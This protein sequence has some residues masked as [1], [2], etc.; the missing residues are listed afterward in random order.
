MSH[1]LKQENI[2][3]IQEI[4]EDFIK[5]DINKKNIEYALKNLVPN[6]ITYEIKENGFSQVAFYQDSKSIIVNID[7]TKKILEENVNTFKK[8]NTN[9][10]EL[11]AYFMLYI[12]T[13][14]IEHS[15]QYLIANNLEKADDKLLKKAYKEIFEIIKVNKKHFSTINQNRLRI[16]RFIYLLK[17]NYMILERNAN[18][19]S[20]DLVVKCA[21]NKEMYEIFDEMLKIILKCGYT[22]N[23]RGCIYET[24]KDLLYLDTYKKIYVP[25]T[26]DEK[27][28]AWYG[29]KITEET[30]DKVLNYKLKI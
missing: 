7:K 18:L 9:L 15:Y 17:Q 23:T 26:L 28:R 22:K 10:K 29:L 11:K 14:E 13:H 25:N 5:N 12:L 8:E 21:K 19:E 30:R 2:D 16:A 20:L 4:I 24:F 1:I 3:I 6:N 27:S